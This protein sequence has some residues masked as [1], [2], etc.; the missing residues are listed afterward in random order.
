MSG[1]FRTQMSPSQSEKRTMLF[2]RKKKRFKIKFWQN[3][4]DYQ[5]VQNKRH[6]TWKVICTTLMHELFLYQKSHWFTGSLC[7]FAALTRSISNKRTILVHKY[8]IFNYIFYHALIRIK[9]MYTSNTLSQH[10]CNS[11]ATSEFQKPSLS[12]CA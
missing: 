10:T 4:A 12:K 2:T 1:N 3:Y 7:K 8:L 5:Y 11:K 9:F 6:T